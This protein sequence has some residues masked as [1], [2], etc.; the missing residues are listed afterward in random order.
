MAELSRTPTH[1]LTLIL[2]WMAQGEGRPKFDSAVLFFVS[3]PPPPPSTKEE[4]ATH[5]N[6]V[7]IRPEAEED[8]RGSASQSIAIIGPQKGASAQSNQQNGDAPANISHGNI[9]K[10]WQDESKI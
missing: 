7:L 2:L 3:T 1:T 9:R 4:E 8:A 5:R 10:Y 6:G